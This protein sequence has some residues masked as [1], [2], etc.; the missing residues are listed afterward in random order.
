MTFFTVQPSASDLPSVALE[1]ALG[2]RSLL[3]AT[4]VIIGGGRKILVDDRPKQV[5]SWGI[6]VG[7]LSPGKGSG[8]I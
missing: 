1:Q 6:C 4:L 7:N 5:W 2:W 3:E 8:V